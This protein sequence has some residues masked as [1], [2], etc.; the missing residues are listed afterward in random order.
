MFVA[1]LSTGDQDNEI[2]QEM[3]PVN[4]VLD[5]EKSLVSDFNILAYRKGKSKILWREPNS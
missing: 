1:V 5:G 4:N 2:L 3:T